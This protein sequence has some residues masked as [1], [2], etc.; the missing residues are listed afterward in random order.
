MKDLD[1]TNYIEGP[2]RGLIE[3]FQS[4]DIRSNIE[5]HALMI[6]TNHSNSWIDYN[7][8]SNGAL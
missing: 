3:A 2:T 4:I 6:K 7:K 5:S 8:T 1:K